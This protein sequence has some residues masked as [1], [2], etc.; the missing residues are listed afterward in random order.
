MLKA[1]SIL[2]GLHRDRAARLRE[3]FEDEPEPSADKPAAPEEPQDE[4][5]PEPPVEDEED[6]F[7]PEDVTDPGYVLDGSP[8]PNF[9]RM[10]Q[11]RFGRRVP[12]HHYAS[13]GG[14]FGGGQ[15]TS[16]SIRI[17]GVQAYHK[18]IGDSLWRGGGTQLSSTSWLVYENGNIALRY[19]ETDVITITPES[20]VTVDVEG[21][22]SKNSLSRVSSF[23]PNDW[24]IA[25]KYQKHGGPTGADWFWYNT[26]S[27]VG[28]HSSKIRI[29]FTD[30][31]QITPDGRLHPQAR[32]IQDLKY[33]KDWP[34]Y[35]LR[36]G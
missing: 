20:V 32:P 4:V 9:Y 33:K 34:P 16:N 10:I 1:R 24:R 35:E 19:H 25:A 28:A 14:M 12:T 17:D 31:D 26:H 29:N 3:A 13:G 5:L 18:V 8:F 36:H 7:S 22:F 2:D 11:G 30:G 21:W 6:E 23:L 27:R 15:S